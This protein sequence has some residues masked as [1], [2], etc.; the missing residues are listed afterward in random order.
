MAETL[1][2]QCRG[3]GFNPWLENWIPQATM[4]TRHTQ[5]NTFFQ[6]KKRGLKWERLCPGISSHGWFSAV[7]PSSTGPIFPS[8]IRNKTHECPDL[9]CD[10]LSSTVHAA[11]P[12]WETTPLFSGP[13]V[14]WRLF[15]LRPG[16]RQ[17][18]FVFYLNTEWQSTNIKSKNFG[19]SF[20][21]SYCIKSVLKIAE[22]PILYVQGILTE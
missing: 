11:S 22:W 13:F 3:P 12:T 2:S 5:I 7:W 21:K 4:K 18:S 1:C 17:I 6:F 14:W 15:S 10:V 8:F 9:T 16:L 19:L 20:Y